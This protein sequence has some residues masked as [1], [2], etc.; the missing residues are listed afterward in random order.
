MNT[1]KYTFLI[2]SLL[3]L[4]SFVLAVP[5]FA[6]DN[7]GENYGQNGS[8]PGQKMESVIGTVT[9]VSGNTI[10]ISVQKKSGGKKGATTTT[11][12][13]IDATNAKITKGGVA[14]T[15]SSIVAGD[16]ISVIGTFTGTNIVATI[17]HS[18]AT[19][20]GGID[21]NRMSPNFV[22]KVTAISGN[23]I[24]INT[25][26]DSEN[27]TSAA[28]ATTVLTID[29]TTARILR[30]ETAI[31]IADVAVGD[32][33]VVQGIKT[34]TNIVAGLIRDGK[35]G[36]GNEGD[37]NQALLQIK[38][39][40]QPIVSGKVSATSGSTI[41]I[42]NSSNITYTIDASSA[43]IIQGKNTI[44]V[45]DVKVGDLL[46]VQGNITGT[47]VTASIIIE[48]NIASTGNVKSSKGIFG[49]VGQW[50]RRLFG[51]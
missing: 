13:T 17:I 23:I 32:N 21:S 18:G 45:S 40:G 31:T 24:T 16:R 33:I 10:T 2:V 41:T 51:F 36:N 20:Q 12:Y 49:S 7:K 19:I 11:T 8:K 14:G 44:S 50:L 48:Q 5:A 46:L 3:I 37:N 34:G 43:K 25:K 38:G 27:N 6:Q 30:G 9:A 1:K 29:A 4:G 26:N 42:T 22:G 39:N 28:P 47:A 15:A 35:V